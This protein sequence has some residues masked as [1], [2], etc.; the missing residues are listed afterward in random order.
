MAH[1]S[2]HQLIP[3]ASS[4]QLLTRLLEMVARG[5]RSTRGLQ[6]A[7]AIEPRTVLYYTQ[8]GEWLGLLESSVDCA[9]TPAGLDYVY[10]GR[11]RSQLYARAVWSN[12]FAAELLAT[13]DG[14]LPSVDDVAEAIAQ[15]EPDLSPATVRRRASSVRSLIAPALDQPRPRSR[16]DGDQQLV[17]PLAMAA[18]VSPPPRI[19]LQSGR[20]YDP[21]AYRYVLEALLEYGE[22][23]LGHVR[24]LLDRSGADEAPIGGYVDMAISRGDAHRLQERLVATRGAV[25]RRDLVETTTSI[26]LSDAQY[27]EYLADVAIAPVD[28]AAEI[29]RDRVADRFRRWDKRL[30]GRPVRYDRVARD[31]ESVLMDRPLES[32]PTAVPGGSEM[33]PV[34]EPFLDVWERDELAICLP[35]Y[36]NQLQGGV[37]AVNR[38]LR[39][40][41]EGGEVALPDIACRPVLFHG[42]IL[43]PGEPLPR[44]VPD[45]RSLRLRVLLHA[46][47]PA[48]MGA[49]LLLH[50][51]RPDLIEFVRMKVGWSIRYRRQRLGGP[52]ELIDDFAKQRG[53][54]PS[55]RG[56]GGL[57][58]DKLLVLLET[59]GIATIG[60]KRALLNERFF[61]RLRTEAEEIEVYDR[62]APLAAAFDAHLET[63]PPRP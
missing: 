27:R 35:P 33:V 13:H 15:L 47:Y 53:W 34:T 32:F 23:S 16:A 51:Q 12:A 37:S 41:R 38:N 39:K 17:L 54:L 29:R 50:R 43:H 24:A 57:S 20:E 60:G 11:R 26:I 22:L 55:R 36:L 19:S 44:S 2:R 8:A 18:A 45:T 3:N 5:V 10:A 42:G 30:F 7:L 59:L 58:T 48:L 1:F 21:D 52:L 4:P 61:T 6:E 9:L 62:L 31:L 40:A 14:G 63:V 49:L 28:R 46:P 25:D 56:S